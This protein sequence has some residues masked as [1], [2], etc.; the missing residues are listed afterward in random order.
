M[1]T[2]ASRTTAIIPGGMLSEHPH[3]FRAGCHCGR[4]L[5]QQ[6]NYNITWPV[7]E[8]GA[9]DLTFPEKENHF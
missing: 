9:R 2:S 1:P 6:P 5:G 7:I 3:L 4:I 8:L